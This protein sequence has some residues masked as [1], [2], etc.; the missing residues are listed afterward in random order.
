MSQPSLFRSEALNHQRHA[1]AGEILVSVAPGWSAIGWL[2]IVTVTALAAF[3]MTSQFSRKETVPGILVSHPDLIRVRALKPGTIETLQVSIGDTVQKGQVLFTVAVDAT[4]GGGREVAEAQLVQLD[5][6]ATGLNQ[7]K[8]LERSLSMQRSA[9]LTS[10]IDKLGQQ[11]SALQQKEKI[12]DRTNELLADQVAAIEGLTAK[13]YSSKVELRRRQTD[14]QDGR[15]AAQSIAGDLSAR[16]TERATALAELEKLPGETQL[17]LS[18]LD[19]ALSGIAQRR[20]DAFGRATYSVT[21]PAA[22]RVDLLQVEPGQAV[23]AGMT[24]VAIQPADAQ[25][26]AELFVPSRAVA[27][28]KQ[29]QRVRIAYDAFPYVQFGFADGKVAGISYTVLHPAELSQPVKVTE[30]GL[31]SVGQAG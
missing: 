26:T 5:A 31:P 4:E 6:E 29:N 16:Q 24:A 20:A 9:E 27:F 25:L 14:L 23:A 28:L 12:Q 8:V 18:Q 19:T 11:I 17:K 7:Q 15:I 21:A 1:I 30:A 22:G 10:R 3:L 2:M 13:G